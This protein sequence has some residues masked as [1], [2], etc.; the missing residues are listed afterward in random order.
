MIKIILAV[1]TVIALL[2]AGADASTSRMLGAASCQWQSA[3]CPDH[4]KPRPVR[5][6]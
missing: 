4:S 1:G 2:P 6:P 5:R 3:S